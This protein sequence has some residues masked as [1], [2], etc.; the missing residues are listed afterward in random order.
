MAAIRKA[1]EDGADWVEIDVQETA[2]GDVVV[3][4]DSDLMRVAGRDLKIWDATMDDLKAIDVGS[5][6]SDDFAAERVPT[7]AAV[8]RQC[9][10][11]IG[12]IIELKYYGHEQ[13]LE[14]RVADIVESTDMASEVM[15]MS[16][17]RDGVRKMK[18]IRPNWKVGLLLSVSIGNLKG[19]EADFFAVNAAFADW[20]FIRAAHDIRKDVYVWTVNDA[21]TMST[22]I[23]RGV[24]GLLTDRP[25]LARSV[26]EQRARMSTP[27]RLLLQLA[28]IL[29][30]GPEIED[31]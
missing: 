3:F 22:M 8:L 31:Q 11:R 6:F 30:A 5:W 1:I 15:L 17:K 10:G 9:R 4:H 28:G 18:K 13:K 14:Q 16:L 23:G 25:A 12:V 7:L 19:V 29:G 26:L 20:S 2:N 24:D 21:R 27:E